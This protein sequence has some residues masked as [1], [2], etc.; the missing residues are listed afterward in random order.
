MKTE[1]EDKVEQKE[2]ETDI[3][4]LVLYNDDVNSFEHVIACLVG[5]CGHS[6][7]QAEQ[8]A[9]IVHNSGKCKVKSGGLDE[10]IKMA[11][12]LIDNDLTVEVV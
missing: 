5:I 8:C 6:S 9:M 12:R 11:E 1:L 10:M 7:H 2:K 3:S 4:V